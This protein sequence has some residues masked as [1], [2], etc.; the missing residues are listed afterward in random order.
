MGVRQVVERIREATRS[1]GAQ[2]SGLTA[3]LE[4][5]F[6]NA[7]A[8]TFVAIALADTVFF[9]VPAGQARAK[10]AL[11]LLTT[12]A[13]FALLA[14]VVGPLLDRFSHGRRIALAATFLARAALAWALAGHDKGL[15][16]YPV[17]L[18]VLVGSR[19]FSLAKSSAVP[20]VLPPGT[21]LVQ[22]N[23]RLAI[24]GVAAAVFMG[25]LALLLSKVFGHSMVL[26]FAAVLFVGGVLLCISLPSHIDD[27]T[28]ETRAHGV[29][30]PTHRKGIQNVGGTPHAL[31]SQAAMR[32]L[33]GFLTLFLAFQL[34]GNGNGTV[35]LGGLAAAASLG[36]AGGVGLG[37]LMRRQRPEGL[38]TVALGFAV[39]ACIAGA[40]IY[41][42][43][44]AL[45]VALV[46]SLSTALGKIALDSVIQRD[47]DPTAQASAFGKAETALQLAWVL[48]GALGL[49]PWSGTWGFGF[50]A[51]GILVA[52]VVRIASGGA[53]ALPS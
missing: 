19:A 52:L 21:T 17:A 33:M 28:G 3:L 47:V 16:I 51:V 2:I 13:P 24:T 29:A 20:R 40:L 4:V 41:S 36:S 38:I 23:S 37:N 46:V 18:G 48:G 39:L 32:G 50:A 25:P 30:L 8:D 7:A 5:C 34:R 43:P 22:A 14:P 27:V 44:I 15:T 10:V 49:I 53:R 42:I 26:R 45:L 9:A 12:M 11:Y 31:R 35:A 6:V 1:G